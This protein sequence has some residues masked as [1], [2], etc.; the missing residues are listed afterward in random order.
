MIKLRKS[1]LKIA[2]NEFAGMPIEVS[3]IDEA[4]ASLDSLTIDHDNDDFVKVDHIASESALHLGEEEPPTISSIYDNMLKTWLAPLPKDVPVRV[5]QRKERL[6]RRIAAEVML[7][8]SRIQQRNLAVKT[9]IDEPGMSQDSGIAMP[10][11]SSQPFAPSSAH[12]ASETSSQPLPTAPYLQIQSQSQSQPQPQPPAPAPSPPD[13]LARLRQHLKFRDDEPPTPPAT[14]PPSVTQLLS[15]WHPHTN[16]TTY[17]YLATE[18]ANHTST[19]DAASQHQ[20]AKARKKKEKR[21]RKQMRENELA[22]SQTASQVPLPSSQPSGFAPRS[23]PGLGLGGRE[24]A[25]TQVPLLGTGIGMQTQGFP[26]AQSQI[27]PG[28]FGG[29]VDGKKKKK[30]RVGGF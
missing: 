6:A 11:F 3:D 7:A 22:K 28:R 15:H 5:R 14:L 18:R 17:D 4:S 1:Q 26:G 19:L 8:S 10:A 23:S 29:R 21:E 30:K 9:A 12:A 16:P 20:L 27:E 25:F 24:F 13:P 2:R